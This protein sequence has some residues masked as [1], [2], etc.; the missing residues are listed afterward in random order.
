M[1]RQLIGLGGLVLWLGLPASAQDVWIGGELQM[2]G[3]IPSKTPGAVR[4]NTTFG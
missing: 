1:A 3:V 4:G 2:T